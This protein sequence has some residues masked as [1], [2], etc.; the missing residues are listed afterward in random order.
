MQ[1]SEMIQTITNTLT[2]TMTTLIGNL[3]NNMDR[4]FDNM[5]KE[6]N[7]LKEITKDIPEMKEMIKR[8]PEMERMIK[9][10]PEMERMI[11]RIPEMDEETRKIS[12]SVAVIEVEHGDKLQALFDA[13]SMNQEQIEKN[14][15]D[16][17]KLEKSYNSHDDRIYLL[18]SKVQGI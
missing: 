11:K 2:K 4:K 6:I 18:E 7:E 14:K 9:R 17:N 8:I 10:I 15:K 13:F 3:E 16:I 1:N 12:K 5:Q